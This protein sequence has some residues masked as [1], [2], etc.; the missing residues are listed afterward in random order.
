MD[1]L[2]GLL[3]RQA[4]MRSAQREL[5]APAAARQSLVGIPAE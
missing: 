2:F 3:Y 4:F 5:R 1:A